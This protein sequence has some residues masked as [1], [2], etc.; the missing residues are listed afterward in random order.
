MIREQKLND[1]S[2]ALRLQRFED[3]LFSRPWKQN[4]NDLFPKLLLS[5][6]LSDAT[7]QYRRFSQGCQS[8]RRR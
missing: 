8:D 2:V 3:M 1:I 4:S 6:K 7:N 5:E